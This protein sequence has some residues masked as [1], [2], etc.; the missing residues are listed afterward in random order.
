MQAWRLGSYEIVRPLGEG[1]MAQVYLARDVRLG[2]EVA[3]KVLDTTLAV[4]PGFKERFLREAQVAAALDHPNIVPLYDFGET[5]G[6]L[7][8]VMPY[9]SGG[10]L[11][12]LLRKVPLP[13]G[14]V[15]TYIAQMAD[16]LAY[17]HERGVVHRDVKPANMLLHADGRLM[18]SDFGLAK[19][20]TPESRARG[21]RHHPDAGT[22][23]YMAPE[24]IEGKSD[25]RS[26]IYGLGV[27]LYL[28]LTGHLPFT[29]A[30][31]SAVMGGHLYRLPDEPRRLNP[32]ITPAMQT[33]VLQALAKHPDD[34]YQTANDLAAALLSA[35]VA[36]DAEPLP[37]ILN[38][39]TPT[40]MPSG[41]GTAPPRISPPSLG[42]VRT[43]PAGA[44]P[45]PR[46][47]D[48]PAAPHPPLAGA[49]ILPRLDQ[50]TFTPPRPPSESSASSQHS[51]VLPLP[52][53]PI[54]P[55]APT[56]PAVPATPPSRQSAAAPLSPLFPPAGPLGMPGL[57][58]LGDDT[59]MQ[60]GYGARAPFVT[61]SSPSLPQQYGAGRPA[62]VPVVP[63]MPPARAPMAAPVSRGPV[64]RMTSVPLPGGSNS[65]ASPPSLPLHAPVAAPYPVPQA[66]VP[67]MP[68]P[69][70]IPTAAPRRRTGAVLLWIVVVVVL[71]ALIAGL[72]MH[73]AQ[74]RPTSAGSSAALA[75]ISGWVRWPL[76]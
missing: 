74:I 55:T 49:E 14:D 4:R 52:V 61:A 50:P 31:S 53:I 6:H 25:E 20:L 30:T 7:Y 63:M 72:V 19:I 47:L 16:A 59:L 10:S 44:Y 76:G 26:D 70:H 34:R 32:A 28:L 71:A 58:G 9:V 41:H 11:Q 45:A 73:L 18:L 60:Q 3:I 42:P 29:G 68:T 2:R 48:V 51:E 33:V 5:E 8:L 62:P 36:G 27:V 17:A 23:E 21:P 39:P 67:V 65:L 1:G 46:S 38:T 57:D 37:F 69:S 40:S 13:A 54:N 56:V 15:V 75:C 43:P 24:Q 35:L 64:R 66:A 22:P 12:D